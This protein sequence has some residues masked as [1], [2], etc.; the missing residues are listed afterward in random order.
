MTYLSKKYFYM[1]KTKRFIHHLL[2]VI[3]LHRVLRPAGILGG[4][5]PLLFQCHDKLA[6]G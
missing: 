5:E 2:P 4:K 3:N 6:I 1:I